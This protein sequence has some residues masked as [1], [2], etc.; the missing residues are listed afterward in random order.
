MVHRQKSLSRSTYL[1]AEL[2]DMC[3]FNLNRYCQVAASLMAVNGNIIISF[4]CDIS[5]AFET[6]QFL[7]FNP[8]FYIG[9][10]FFP[11]SWEIAVAIM[12]LIL[13]YFI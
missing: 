11:L 12:N 2:L 8:I 10:L 7:K 1:G 9:N 13:I 4:I 5:C 3:I 6:L